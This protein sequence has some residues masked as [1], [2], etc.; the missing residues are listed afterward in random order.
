[1]SALPRPELA[2]GPHRDLVDALHDLHHRAGWP[3]LRALARETGVSHTTVSHALSSPKI[4][5][6]GTLELLVEAMD[7]DT[8]T[9]HDLWLTATTPTDHARPPTPRIAGRKPELTAVRRHLETGT[10]LLLV[11]GEAGIGKTTLVRAAAATTDA[12]VAT[13]HCLPLS[14]EVPLMPVIDALVAIHDVDDGRWFDRALDGLPSSVPRSLSRLVPQLTGE[15]P[16]KDG[17]SGEFARQHLFTALEM[18]L[19]RLAEQRR[20]ALLLE[21]LHWADPTTLDLLDRLLQHSPPVAV[22]GSWRTEDD[23]TPHW[24]NDWHAR[25]AR[26]PDVHVLPLGAL[27]REETADQLSLL[28]A[29]EL[30]DTIHPRSQGQPLFTEQLAAHVDG[31]GRLPALLADLLDRRLEGLDQHAWVVLRTLG[32]AERPLSPAQLADASDLAPGDLVSQLRRLRSRRLLGPSLDEMVRI[33]HPLLAEATRR[34]LVP[35]ERNVIHRSLAE[36]LGRDPDAAAAEVA[37][38]WR[39]A[40]DRERELPW[41]VKA[42]RDSAAALDWRQEADHWLRVLDLWPPRAVSVGDPSVTRPLAYVAAIDALKESLQWGRAAA[43]SDAAEEVLGEVDDAARVELLLRAADFRGDRDGMAVGLELVDRAIEISSRLPADA[44]YLHV[45][46]RRRWQ[47]NSL[48]RYDE[49]AAEARAAVGVAEA[50]DEPHLLRQQLIG[51]AWHEGL[52]GDV[53]NTLDLLARGRAFLADGD[54]PLGDIRSATIATDVLLLHGGALDDIEDAARAGLDAARDWGI[55]N[56]SSMAL[57]ANLAQARLRAGQVTAAGAVVGVAAED[58]PDPD[59]W[60]THSVRAAVDVRL[61]H[62]DSAAHRIHV[63]LSDVLVHDEI[64]LDILCIASDVDF[65][66][67]SGHG[68]LRRLLRDL[69]ATVDRAPSRIV[70]PGLVAAARGVADS[71][72]AGGDPSSAGVPVVQS[73]LSRAGFGRRAS[74]VP[75]PHVAAHM[76]TAAAEL[77]RASGEDAVEDWV[78]AAA[79]WDRLTRPHDAAYCRWRGAQAALRDGQATVARRLLERAAAD[80]RE[81][82]PLHRAISATVAGGH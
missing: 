56:E 74:D 57:R 17:E 1:M 7:G 27:T 32:V 15:M 44:T 81:H 26:R 45:L 6:W 55:D 2:P 13:G 61:G 38:H 50:L 58:P 23:S 80:A 75:D 51:L 24:S 70:C 48:G 43:M 34:R 63:L 41:R 35:G 12:F 53:S 37:N 46:N 60:M 31:E 52:E 25:V 9:F 20:L 3:S 47:L 65:W 49:A 29:P 82:V 33:R 36:A 18:V 77:A 19:G 21:D 67:G 22:V 5:T 73:L 76:T 16:D 39:S 40:G 72:T 62:V 64:D 42:A 11:T 14:T 78:R 54:D 66:R 10:G 28:G 8:T 59:R 69:D 68:W 4:P 79:L 30:L 71:A